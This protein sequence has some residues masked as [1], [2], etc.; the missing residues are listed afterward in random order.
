MRQHHLTA[1]TQAALTL[2]LGACGAAP[3]SEEASSAANAHVT[4]ALRA[5]DST[6]QA[7]VEAKD[8]RRTAAMYM[9]DAMLMP[10]AEP[11]V[12]GRA[13]IAREWAKLYG[14]PGFRNHAKTTRVEVAASGDLGITQGTYEATMTGADGRPV[15]EGGKW[16]TVWRRDVDGQWRATTD[17]AN[18][19][20]PP[21]DHQ[22]S[23]VGGDPARPA[24]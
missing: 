21:P 5:A 3:G 10:V 6:L 12:V 24:R 20:A 16:V 15:V 2:A 14:I 8:A 11:A 1:V 17:I 18:T 9:A 7:A 23:N 13:A 19:D 22:E 4:A